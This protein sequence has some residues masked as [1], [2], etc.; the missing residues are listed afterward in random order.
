[1]SKDDTYNNIPATE[2]DWI[3]KS[4]DPKHSLLAFCAKRVNKVAMAIEGNFI[5]FIYHLSIK[6]SKI[7]INIIRC[8]IPTGI[9]T[10]KGHSSHESLSHKVNFKLLFKGGDTLNRL[11]F[12]W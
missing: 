7:P 10:E 5:P 11:D 6:E 12:N 2:A 4:S 8:I 1:M 3:I 9:Q